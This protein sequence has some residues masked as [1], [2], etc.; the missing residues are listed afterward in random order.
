MLVL[1]ADNSDLAFQVSHPAVV[2]V[3]VVV[4]LT[5]LNMKHC[6]VFDEISMI[7]SKM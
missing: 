4:V 3:V 1:C 7:F 5:I 6:I 2:V